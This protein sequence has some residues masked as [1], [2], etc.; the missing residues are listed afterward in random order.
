MNFKKSPRRAERTKNVHEGTTNNNIVN[1]EQL[2]PAGDYAANFKHKS[3]A[4]W[5]QDFDRRQYI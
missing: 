2:F 3:D 4:F 1:P 5:G